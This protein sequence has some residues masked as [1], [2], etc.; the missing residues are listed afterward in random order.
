M[1][2]PPSSSGRA[3][4]RVHRFGP[5]SRF[6]GALAGALER[7]DRGDGARVLDALFVGRDAADGDSYAIDLATAR[8]DGSIAALLDF[9]LDPARR[10][11]TT[12]RALAPHAGGVP[13]QLVQAVA[14]ALEPG[15]AILAILVSDGAAEA[16]EDALSRSGGRELADEPVD[17]AGL[18]ALGELITA[19]L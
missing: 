1:S 11:D 13:P 4:L 7:M 9:R 15:E 17:A 14:G 16:L 19:A 12:Q 8:A 18:A 10:R 6:E 2:G 3:R 5:Q